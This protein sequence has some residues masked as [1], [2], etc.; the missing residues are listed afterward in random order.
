ML[1][2]MVDPSLLT[3]DVIRPISRREYERMAE[4]GFFRDD[5]HVELLEG[6]LVKMSPQGWQHA[7]VIQRL[8]MLLARS[9]DPSLAVR[10]QLPF[11]AGRFSMPE[12]DIAVVRDDLRLRDHPHQ[13]LLVAEVAGDSIDNDRDAKLVVYARA[14]VPEYWIIDLQPMLVE[15][16]TQPKGTRYTRKDVLHVGDVLRPV[17]L[18]GVEIAISDLPR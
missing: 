6:V 12:P 3:A 15:V 16:Y 18:S 2:A 9:I 4:L 1:S 14:R 17:L 13:A 7:A 8:T 5:E 10:T 11:N